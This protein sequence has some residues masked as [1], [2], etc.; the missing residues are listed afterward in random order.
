MRK[1][2]CG[3]SYQGGAGAL[4]AISSRYLKDRWAWD[5]GVIAKAAVRA[6][7]KASGGEA[8]SKVWMINGRD[9][10]REAQS[11]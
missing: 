7:L 6:V 1:S 2:A 11:E 4:R 8:P 10:I 5:A 3:S 9:T